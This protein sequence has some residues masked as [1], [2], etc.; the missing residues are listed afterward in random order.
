[1]TTSNNRRITALDSRLTL[2]GAVAGSPAELRRY[3][4]RQVGKLLDNPEFVNA[5]SGHT[6][7]SRAKVLIGCCSATTS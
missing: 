4:S 2:V 1:M 3:I 7:G 6:A 5:M